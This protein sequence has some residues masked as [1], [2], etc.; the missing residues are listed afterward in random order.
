MSTARA[1]AQ[2]EAGRQYELIESCS[3]GPYLGARH[4]AR[5]DLLGQSGGR[6]TIG[7]ADLEDVCL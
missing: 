5:L 3:K 2:A 4:P 6:R 1:F 7:V